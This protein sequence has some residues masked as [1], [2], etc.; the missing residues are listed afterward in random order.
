M[1]DS[2]DSESDLEIESIKLDENFIN[3][4][5]TVLMGDDLQRIKKEIEKTEKRCK[6]EQKKYKKSRERQE[7]NDSSKPIKCNCGGHYF[8]GN[9]TGHI[10]TVKHSMYLKDHEIFI[11]GKVINDLL[12]IV[13][14]LKNKTVKD[15]NINVLHKLEEINRMNKAQKFSIEYLCESDDL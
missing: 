15:L 10:R 1:S 3:I 14:L 9:K 4:L 13:K 5:N 6:E 7:Y 2:E 12:D 11:R 8:Y